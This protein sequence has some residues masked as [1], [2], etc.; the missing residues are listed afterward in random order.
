MWIGTIADM[1]SRVFVNCTALLACWV[2]CTSK[3]SRALMKTGAST[4]MW[5]STAA[6]VESRRYQ[7]ELAREP[8]V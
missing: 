2:P 7:V 6:S 5:R 1:W 4:W 8:G 3:G